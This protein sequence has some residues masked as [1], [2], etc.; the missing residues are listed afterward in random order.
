MVELALTHTGEDRLIN[1]STTNN[2]NV[3]SRRDDYLGE[4]SNIGLNVDGSFTYWGSPTYINVQNKGTIGSE[5]KY[6]D[7]PVLNQFAGTAAIE[8][9][10]D[11]DL[12]DLIHIRSLENNMRILTKNIKLDGSGDRTVFS[13][14]GF[15]EKLSWYLRGAFNPVY[16]RRGGAN[17]DPDIVD[18]AYMG[19]HTIDIVK[20]GVNI[21]KLLEQSFTNT[22]THREYLHVL[23]RFQLFIK[24]IVYIIVHGRISG[25]SALFGSIPNKEHVPDDR[26]IILQPMKPKDQRTSGSSEDALIILEEVR[27]SNTA[28]DISPDTQILE[29]AYGV[30]TN[31]TKVLSRGSTGS[32]IRISNTQ[33]P[34]ATDKWVAMAEIA[35]QRE[36]MRQLQNSIELTVSA[37]PAM[38]TTNSDKYKVTAAKAVQDVYKNIQLFNVIR[39]RDRWYRIMDIRTNYKAKNPTITMFLIYLDDVE[40][41]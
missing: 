12:A 3:V 28:P 25:W 22:T 38:V 13:S 24:G 36:Y 4:H 34:Y 14:T 5:N 8:D 1:L 10:G 40:D 31:E 16:V 35:L 6:Q 9:H 15:H 39:Y 17:I 26:S 20:T 33:F 7:I 2:I 19:V 27:G 23:Q 21:T 18:D 32:P 11:V 29:R 41:E 30:N 37:R